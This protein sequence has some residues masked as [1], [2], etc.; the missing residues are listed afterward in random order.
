MKL[1]DIVKSVGSEVVKNVV[2]GGAALVSVVNELLPDEYKLDRNSA[3]GD[4]INEALAK[5]PA[6]DRAELLNREFDVEI[7]TIKEEHSTVRT[8][9]EAEQNSAHTTRPKIA[10]GAFHV[11]AYSVVFTVS[12]WSYAVYTENA[13]M[14]ETI[15]DGWPFVLGVVAPLVT[16]LNSYFGVLKQE[17]RDRLNAINGKESTGGGLLGII[18]NIIKR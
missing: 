11:I 1:W 9:L 7:T 18:S 2:P 10:L 17:Q 15:M 12:L 8:M 6:A 16:L 4:D 14:V 3:T 5:V 13:E